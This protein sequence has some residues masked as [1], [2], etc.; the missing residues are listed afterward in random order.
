MDAQVSFR[1]QALDAALLSI[2]LS[3][4]KFDRGRNQCLHVSSLVLSTNSI[5]CPPFPNMPSAAKP[6]DSFSLP[7]EV[8]DL[9][10]EHGG[11]AHASSLSFS[12]AAGH[13][14][15]A[16]ALAGPAFLFARGV[17]AASAD[18]VSLE[19][20]RVEGGAAPP[21][22][23]L[24]PA[25][26]DGAV[27][28]AAL[29]MD[30]AVRVYAHAE[31]GK[32]VPVPRELRVG[33]VL[34]RGVGGDGEGGCAALRLLHVGGDVLV[35]FGSRDSAAR[36]VVEGGVL[37]ARVMGRG[38]GGGGDDVS[39][40]SALGDGSGG[41]GGGFG[42]FSA[43]RGVVGTVRRADE[44]DWIAGTGDHAIVGVG[45]GS[46]G[47]AFSVRRGGLVD[48][49]GV[50]TL[51]WSA[52]VADLARDVCPVGSTGFSVLGAEVSPDEVVAAL[53]QFVLDGQ[54]RLAV[55]C[56]DG[57][58]VRPPEAVSLFVEMGE[59]VCD[60]EEIRLVMSAGIL[61][62]FLGSAGVVQWTSVSKGVALS[63]QVSGQYEVAVSTLFV[64]AVDCC[65]GL[66]VDSCTVGGYAGF[67]ETDRIV[68]MSSQVPGPVAVQDTGLGS[69][70]STLSARYDT[71]SLLWLAF[72]QFA[73]GQLG[74]S[75]AT[76]QALLS[77]CLDPSGHPDARFLD[78]A[79][80]RASTSI[81]DTPPN[82][83]R[84]ASPMTLLV[85]SQLQE[86]QN[87]HE[88]LLAMLANAKLL[89]TCEYADQEEGDRLWDLLSDRSRAVVVSNAEKLAAANRLR[90]V[91]NSHASRERSRKS[92]VGGWASTVG[93]SDRSFATSAMTSVFGSIADNDDDE[94]MGDDAE[95]MRRSVV[96]QALSIA[97]AQAL[98]TIG[99]DP[100]EP[101]GSFD[102][103]AVAL[104]G[105]VSGFDGF[106]PALRSCVVAVVARASE[107]CPSGGG[108]DID[109][110]TAAVAARVRR[111][112]CRD[113]ILASDAALA[114]IEAAMEVREEAQ[115]THSFELSTMEAAGGWSCHAINSRAV[116][117]D[118]IVAAFSAAEGCRPPDAKALKKCASSVSRVLLECARNAHLEEQ[119]RSGS[120]CGNPGLSPA[121]RR[122][123]SKADEMNTI[124]G[125][126]RHAALTMLRK[127][128]LDEETFDLARNFEDF[129]MM[130]ALRC[131]SDGFND[132]FESAVEE[133]GREFASYAFQWL[134]ERGE[135]KLLVFGRGEDVGVTRSAYVKNL[136]LEYF[137][138]DRK[139]VANL[140]WMLHLS[141][142]DF[143]AAALGLSQQAKAVAVPGKEGSLPNARLLLSI[144]KLVTHCRKS[145]PVA[146]VDPSAVDAALV[147][148]QEDVDRRLYL[149]RAQHRLDDSSNSILPCAELV[150]RFILTAPV[151]SGS[152]AEN[153]VLAL[154]T[155]NRSDL[156]SVEVRKSRDF[157]W[158]HCV[159]RQSHFW[160]KI[161]SESSSVGD[162]ELR[163]QLQNTALFEAARSVPLRLNDARDLVLRGVFDLED[164]PKA[165][166]DTPLG[167]RPVNQLGRLVQTAVQLAENAA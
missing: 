138:Q 58:G 26:G 93:G 91:Q 84:S 152:L 118:L 45:V 11:A 79:A 44:A 166:G 13:V 39:A 111:L 63:G 76:M 153:V 17:D 24:W 3:C 116:L 21:A 127:H 123:L 125:K 82:R 146:S 92:G 158:Q 90:S 48:K 101:G 128:G 23:A 98:E 20:P 159:R 34:G 46:G 89:V 97:G 6:V 154:E 143:S 83:A 141:S 38:G 148:F 50:E 25:A 107:S 112:A 87:R 19:V 94:L 55:V 105:L 29:G 103:T 62:T 77:S 73:G 155:L 124:W 35:V 4:R 136:L 134:E 110:R 42:L 60:V 102:D 149:L 88:P 64:A 2:R 132:F 164:M 100:G 74:A 40:S 95:N 16:G 68:L 108:F 41:V 71:N 120:P 8:E 69:V 139:K 133:F 31:V 135:I 144:A 137:R 140:A 131:N 145:K 5:S 22:L 165:V 18:V 114:V 51:L 160:V 122:R 163:R 151:D 72:L 65:G 130:L 147:A 150:S 54:V 85:D 7:A 56:A 43:L 142:G 12:G 36:V 119:L 70:P 47:A 78:D 121:K 14:V 157:V 162:G 30:G 86:K 10:A 66:P 113:I 28:V 9:I 104:Y 156:S 27:H 167:G 53:V 33:S 81:V 57:D 109:E 49:W 129:G 1:A 52:N 75:E 115:A 96:S 67:V 61:F 80:I 32:P 161:V 106:L 117:N 59:L 99:I 15:A 126:E 37:S